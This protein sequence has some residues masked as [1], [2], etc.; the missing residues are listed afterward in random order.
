MAKTKEP[1]IKDSVLIFKDALSRSKMSPMLYQN[2]IIYSR[3]KAGHSV[4]TAVEPELWSWAIQDQDIRSMLTMYDIKKDPDLVSVFRYGEGMDYEDWIPLDPEKMYSG[5]LV[6][7]KI[8]GFEYDIPINVKVFPLKLRKNEFSG[9]SYRVTMTDKVVL[10]IRK[11]F[12]TPITGTSF[13]MVIPFQV[14]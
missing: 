13:Y 6:Q 9:F 2:R 12:E 4:L 10:S 8:D 7:L 11:K 14:I 1:T 5:D 3:H